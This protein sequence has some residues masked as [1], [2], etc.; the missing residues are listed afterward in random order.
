M[1]E[2]LGDH[3]TDTT[4]NLTTKEGSGGWRWLVSSM[5]RY[6]FLL[7]AVSLGAAAAIYCL[8]MQGRV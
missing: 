1:G 7:L 5:W 6:W 8:W 2:A 3:M 4:D